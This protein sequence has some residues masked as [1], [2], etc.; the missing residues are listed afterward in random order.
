[1]KKRYKLRVHRMTV[2]ILRWV[3][4][5]KIF[6]PDWEEVGRFDSNPENIRRCKNIIRQMNECDAHTN[7]PNEDDGE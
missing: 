1:M 5:G 7:H 6:G 4:E 3:T 2:Y